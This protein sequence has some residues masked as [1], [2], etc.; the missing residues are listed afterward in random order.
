MTDSIW[1]NVVRHPRQPINRRD[2]TWE[3]FID[4]TWQVANDD[5]HPELGP[6]QVAASI[7]SIRL[8]PDRPLLICHSPYR[9]ARRGAEL[10]AEHFDARM[11]TEL[12]QVD[13]LREADIVWQR[14]MTREE[15][16][17]PNRP[18]TL[19]FERIMQA[20][21]EDDADMVRGGRSTIAAQAQ[22]LRGLL[23]SGEYTNHIWVGH[24]PVMPFI[25]MAI[26]DMLPPEA[27]TTKRAVLTGMSDFSTGFSVEIAVS[28]NDGRLRLLGIISGESGMMNEGQN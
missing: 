20:I 22:E 18:G 21:A 10:Q 28:R 19:A 7:Q 9:R 14:I 25:H 5:V 1:L 15:Y 17:D 13:A 11:P 23:E 27:W 4:P 3:Q 12:R 26:V 6:A 2:A 16:N 8:N 24:A